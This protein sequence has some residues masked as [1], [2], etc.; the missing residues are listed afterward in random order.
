[1]KSASSIQHAKITSATLVANCKKAMGQYKN[2]QNP[3]W[4]SCRLQ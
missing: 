2:H 3:T 4:V 1:M